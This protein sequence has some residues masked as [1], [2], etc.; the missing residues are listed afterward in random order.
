M[1]EKEYCSE[2]QEIGLGGGVL[3]FAL[4]LVLG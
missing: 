3:P 1:W 2:N 4:T